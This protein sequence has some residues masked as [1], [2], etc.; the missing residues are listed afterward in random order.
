M[1]IP[2]TIK[3]RL[4]NDIYRN[5][6]YRIDNNYIRVRN[7]TYRIDNNYM[8]GRND[9]YMRGNRSEIKPQIRID[10]NKINKLNRANSAQDIYPADE[11]F[12]KWVDTC[13]P[14]TGCSEIPKYKRLTDDSRYLYL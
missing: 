12:M 1:D 6:T 10:L 5:N 3:L 9:I 7:D 4:R 8:R 14:D 2:K 11:E 13:S